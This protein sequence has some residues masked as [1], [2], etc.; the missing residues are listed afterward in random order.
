MQL[1]G[2]FKNGITSGAMAE[3]YRFSIFNITASLLAERTLLRKQ[4]EVVSQYDRRKRYPNNERLLD[5]F[6]R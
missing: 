2:W 5:S 1:S 3:N 4:D 6:Q